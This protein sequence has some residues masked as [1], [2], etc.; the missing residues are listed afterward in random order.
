MESRLKGPP[1]KGLVGKTGP[2]KK[3]LVGKTEGTSSVRLIELGKGA[4]SGERD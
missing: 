1:K 2:Q 3:G 4:E